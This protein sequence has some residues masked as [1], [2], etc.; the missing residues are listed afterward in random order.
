M[1]FA[2]FEVD[3]YEKQLKIFM[4]LKPHTFFK[5]NLYILKKHRALHNQLSSSHGNW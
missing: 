2:N 1:G 3:F 4:T 5:L